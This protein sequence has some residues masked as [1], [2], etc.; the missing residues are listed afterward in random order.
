MIRDPLAFCDY[1]SLDEND[2]R[3]VVANLPPPG[4]RQYGNVS[5]NRPLNKKYEYDLNGE[6]GPRYEVANLAHNPD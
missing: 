1:H 2:V 6:K 3:T 4:A 5:A